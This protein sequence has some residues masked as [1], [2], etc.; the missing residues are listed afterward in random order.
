VR[1]ASEAI[2]ASPITFVSLIN[3]DALRTVLAGVDPGALEGRTLVNLTAGS[4]GDA[5]MIADRVRGAGGE[6]LDGNISCY[7]DAIGTAAAM[8][9]YAGPRQ[10]FDDVHAVLGDLGGDPRY[11][12]EDYAAANALWLAAAV[13]HTGQMLAMFLAAAYGDVYGLSFARVREQVESQRDTDDWYMRLAESRIAADDYTL[14]A[15]SVEVYAELMGTF[16]ADMRSHDM[17]S[18]LSD[19]ALVVLRDASVL[20]HGGDEFLVMYDL[21]RRQAV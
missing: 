11:V 21:F 2:A 4:P 16:V 15:A 18:Q 9:M 14:G 20:G 1:S 6:Y 3:Y 7:P 12:S 19:A 5:R 8:T 10:V 13:A 17:R